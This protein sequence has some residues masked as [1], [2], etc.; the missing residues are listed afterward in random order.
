MAKEKP[1]RIKMDAETK[2]WFKDHPGA[3][4][5]VMC[6]EK[7]CLWYKPDLGHN[8]KASKHIEGKPLYTMEGPFV[9]G[10]SPERIEKFLNDVLKGE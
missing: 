7:C 3:Q 1:Q 5:T 8:C 2:K 6:C 9:T 4:T 10:P